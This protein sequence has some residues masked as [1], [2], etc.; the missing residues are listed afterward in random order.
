MTLNYA[1]KIKLADRETLTVSVTGIGTYTQHIE[2]D[3][4]TFSTHDK[5]VFET[6]LKQVKTAG[7][8]S[9]LQQS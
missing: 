8:W 3:F 6:W 7:I 2:G 5:K 1:I 9:E 4:V